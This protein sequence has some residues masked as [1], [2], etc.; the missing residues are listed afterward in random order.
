M[1]FQQDERAICLRVHFRHVPLIRAYGGQGGKP[2]KQL[3]L[4]F[5]TLE[6][7]LI[8]LI[9]GVVSILWT[10]GLMAVLGIPMNALTAAVP[11]LPCWQNARRGSMRWPQSC[12][13]K[14]RRC[15]C[16][17]GLR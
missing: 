13:N 5:R 6:G 8:P 10:V 9:T 17:P 1:L 12:S 15:R 3:F 16:A 2:A 4:A 14:C 7:M 11:S